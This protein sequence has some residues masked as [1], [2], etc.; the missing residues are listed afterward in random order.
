MATCLAGA[1]VLL[2]VSGC[3]GDSSSFK[4][5]TFSDKDMCI[6]RIQ[7]HKP[8]CYGAARAEVE[9]VLTGGE[10]G[11][12]T[13]VLYDSGVFVYYRGDAVV[14]FALIEG[15]E[16]VYET[17]RGARIGMSK[18]EL[19]DL[20]GRKY[21]YEGT[22]YNLDYAYD[23][24]TGKLVDKTKVY[25]GPIQQK[26]EQIYRMSA[27]FDGNNGGGASFIGLLDQKM[28]LFME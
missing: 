16:D 28:A 21:A 5:E 26:K 7:D 8:L 19:M 24:K 18:K 4:A 13:R 22:E 12:A 10:E 17:A 27:M 9:K 6:E 1:F 23:S 14:G 15:S 2:A 11:G 25:S 20:Y 3:S